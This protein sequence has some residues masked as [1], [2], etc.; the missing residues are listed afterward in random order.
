M[1]ARTCTCGSGAHPRHCAT[2]PERFEEHVAEI[3]AVGHAERLL[4]LNPF[5]G[6]YYERFDEVWTDLTELE[7]RALVMELCQLIHKPSLRGGS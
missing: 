6:G 2:H 7:R 3:S 5:E 4:E 1:S